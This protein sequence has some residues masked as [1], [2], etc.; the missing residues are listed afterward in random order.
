MR[1]AR[2]AVGRHEGG[3]SEKRGI[4]GQTGRPEMHKDSEKWGQ[5]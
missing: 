4:T 5:R 3:N 1:Q 2:R